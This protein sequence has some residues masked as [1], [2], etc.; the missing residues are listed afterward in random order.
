MLAK[1]SDGEQNRIS[2]AESLIQSL[3]DHNVEVL[4]GYPGGAVL[5]IYDTFYTSAFRNILT[6]HEQGAAHAAEGYAKVTG[7]TGVICVTS[8]PG[9]S[10]A[11]TGIAD[12]MMDSTPMVV[13]TG[14]VS[15]ES[16]GTH[17]FQELDVISMTK[18]VTKENFQVINSFELSKTLDRAFEVAQSGRKGPVLVDLPKDVMAAVYSEELPTKVVKSEKL[19]LSAEQK[20]QLNTILVKLRQAK[21]P[22]LLLGA[23]VG[24]ADAGLL[25]AEFSYQWQVPVVSTLLGLGVLKNDDPLFLGMG[26]MHGSY[27]A[28]M[29]FQECDFLLN[30]GSRFD[31]RLVPNVEKFA[32]YAEVAHVDID[33]QE[34]GRI[35]HTKYSATVDAGL[36][37]EYMTSIP[38][39]SRST[40]KWL[41]RT[42]KN[43]TRH[44]FKY[45]QDE[46]L[47]K[48]QEVIEAV[49]KVT[50]GQ[51]TVVTDVGQHQMWAAQFY[52][53]HYPRQLV[54][55]GGLGTMGF[56]LPA[57]IGAKY[58]DPDK[59][60]VLFVGD[61][62]LQMTSEELEVLA[63]EKLNIK[64][65]LLN[66]KTLGMVR[67]WQDEFYDQRRSQ[68]VFSHQ[69]DFEKLAGAYGVSYYDLNKTDDL[70]SK[71]QKIFDKDEPALVN[72]KIPSLEQ[73]YPM[74]A[75]GCSN[76]DMLG[77]D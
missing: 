43:E 38:A 65:V 41:E 42:Q 4:F 34:I 58:A 70:E 39:E 69:P 57:A 47:L 67:Q 22:L 35:V 29:A 71:L 72:V 74:I 31:D 56:G 25:A 73:V 21:K 10:N 14:Q 18:V 30:I 63:A 76:D 19:K 68:T 77:L 61:G 24:A 36:A 6:R 8:G 62:G 26:G 1:Q 2:G 32:P 46:D 11:I 53:F 60:V 28:N 40:R 44:P 15:T 59:D 45:D 49:G 9:A 75:P 64:I 55:S 33:P 66:N 7:K 16:I 54:T 12:A 52:P 50:H 27:A 13:L 48:P 20:N 17:A 51:A 3:V 23:G 37:L 5:P